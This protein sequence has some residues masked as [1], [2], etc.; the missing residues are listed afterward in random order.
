MLTEEEI[1]KKENSLSVC[2]SLS[3]CV[4]AL[5]NM[6]V[7]SGDMKYKKEKS[8][9]TVSFSLSFCLSP[10]I[11]IYVLV[12]LYFFHYTKHVHAY[13]IWG[14]KRLGGNVLVGVG[15]NAIGGETTR[16][17]GANDQGWK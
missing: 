8:R 17:W 11:Q 6:Y 14:V 5:L 9:R 4:C 2:V 3:L 13:K 12:K 16:I 1:K 15:G 7:L 10:L